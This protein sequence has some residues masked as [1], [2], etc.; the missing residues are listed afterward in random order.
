M[1]EF[2]FKPLDAVISHDGIVILGLTLEGKRLAVLD[3][4]Y[5]PYVL[6]RNTSLADF[7]ELC[8]KEKLNFVHEQK[9]QD[10]SKIFFKPIDFLKV[11]SICKRSD[12]EVY[13]SDIALRR[14]YFI[15]GP[16]KHLYIHKVRGPTCPQSNFKVDF[17]VVAEELVCL[18]QQSQPKI[19]AFDIETASSKIFPN[20]KKDPIISIALYSENLKL[21]LTWKRFPKAPEHVL[22]CDSE[23][24]LISKFQEI[25][26]KTNPDL[27]VGY[28]SDNFDFRYLLARA[29]QYGFE[30]GLNWV[31]QRKKQRKEV[32]FIGLQYA[33]IS[34]FVMF[35]LDLDVDRYGLDYVANALLGKKKLANL[36]PEKINEIW[37][38]GL[39]NELGF[40]M[41]Y[42]L[43]DAQL[44]YE[45][46]QKIL[47]LLLE[48]CKLVKL[49]I[50]N[51][52]YSTYGSLVEWYIIANANIPIPQKPKSFLLAKRANKTFQGGFVVEP[53]PGLYGNIYYFDF[54]SLYPSIIVSH[55]I[56]PEVLNCS[57]CA[58][59]KANKID[60]N[61]WFCSEKEGF[62]PSLVKELID[63][64]KRVKEILS[65]VPKGSPSYIELDARQHALKYI[66]A[67]IFGYLGFFRSR[68]YCFD[69]ARSI[70]FLGRKYIDMAIGE[71]K[72]Y[73][74]EI[75]YG[76]TDGFFAQ[77]ELDPYAF[78]KIINSVLPSPMELELKAKYSSGL[79]FGRKG[80]EGG[81]KKRYVLLKEN[82][83][84]VIR[85]LEAIRSDW[86][87]LAKNAQ[88]EVLKKILID[89][90]A[91]SA[92]EYVQN[93]IQKIKERKVSLDDLAITVR[94]T[95][96]LSSYA[97]KSPH[98]VAAELARAQKRPLYVGSAIK[99]I[100]VESD[101]KLKVK[102]FEDASINDYDINYYIKN[103]LMRAVYKI[104]ELFNI[105]LDTLVGQKTLG[106]YG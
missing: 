63:R 42:N 37:S 39:E 82:N 5:L 1:P 87:R 2:L 62:L 89:R 20:S 56:S 59:K 48:L 99:Y 55:N 47:P 27:L 73:G 102:L 21:V 88:K 52:L 93:L 28:G 24:E 68:F 19:L 72:K 77:G 70:T 53:K 96:K 98:V 15:D 91:Q 106:D 51:V 6:V 103:Q 25:V 80:K 44:T 32:D 36:S 75:L 14:R 84:L 81:A 13:N 78:L 74:F 101:G 26:N 8:K 29:K 76:D 12:L 33:D 50:R 92:K 40:L 22:F 49:S 97:A 7:L 35:I 94:L 3:K 58:A 67:A 23:A 4:N 34:H 69:C 61:T 11:S 38:V 46:A 85:G 41:D 57:C 54:R 71:A 86:S 65:G 95:K 100:V 31:E 9:E 30:L 18:D 60:D 10:F 64:R 16:S 83:E 105:N 79:F 104:F 45:I 90:N 43:T 66:A 17:A